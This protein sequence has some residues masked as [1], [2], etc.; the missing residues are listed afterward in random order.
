MTAF[1]NTL[2][3][4]VYRMGRTMF[5]RD[6]FFEGEADASAVGTL[7][8]ATRYEPDDYFQNTVP[9]TKFF[10]VSTT[11]GAA[12]VGEERQA[13]DFTQS[14]GSASVAP[15]WT[16]APGVGDMYIGLNEYSWSQIREAINAAIDVAN[17]LGFREEKIDETTELVAA[18]YDYA[19]PSGF[20]HI[21]R[22]TMANDDG[23]FFDPIPA[24]QWS[25]RRALSPPML[26]FEPYPKSKK[27]TDIYYGDNWFDV[28]ATAG[29]LVRIEGLQKQ[30]HLTNPTD[31]CYINPVF[32]TN[33]AMALLHNA[34]VTSTDPDEHKALATTHQEVANSVGLSVMKQMPA[35]SKRV[36]L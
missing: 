17:S 26:R 1:N 3:D 5:K 12:P 32:I 29:R 31:I 16:A 6:E 20:T 30:E 21:Y 34:R 7:V 36:E 25:V 22:V 2:A 18:V 14:S 35:D 33:Q 10:I 19:I 11:D 13:T 27:F 4:L 23:D 28:S 8:D 15:N 9:V 24:E